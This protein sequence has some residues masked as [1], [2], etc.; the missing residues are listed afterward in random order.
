L[1]SLCAGVLGVA[2]LDPDAGFVEQG[3]DSLSLLRVVAAAG[4]RGL[5]VPP[6]LLADSRCLRDVAGWL[7][8]AS[9]ARP[10][11]L[12]ADRLRQDIAQVLHET[13]LPRPAAGPAPPAAQTILMTG[14]TGFFGGHLLVELLRQTEAEIVC[15][16]RASGARAGHE[17]LTQALTQHGL[18]VRTEE[19]RRLGVVAGDLTQ[20]LMGLAQATWDDLARRIDAI[21]H[22]AAH[23]NLALGYDRLRPDNVLGTFEVLRLWSAQ[24]PCWLHH[25]S[26]L[27]VLVATDAA[28]PAPSGQ[29][30]LGEEIDLSRTQWVHGGYA[31]S[32]WAAEWLVRQAT[33][34]AGVTHYRPGLIT[35]DSR[36][37]PLPRRDFLT[38]FL[39]GL[40]RLGCLPPCD[41][42]AL[43][44]DVTPVDYAA[45]ALAYLSLHAA[46]G[47]GDTFH[48]AGPR[49]VSLA[50]LAAALRLA[51]VRLDEVDAGGWRDR[52][53]RFVSDDPEAAAACLALCRGLPGTDDL[54]ERYRTLDLFQATGVRFGTE[55][56]QAGLA[57]LG[58][59]CVAIDNAL[60]DR[61]VAAALAT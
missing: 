43:W 8:G 1:L 52:L 54:F 44:L 56:T 37:G 45:R 3:G 20:P 25:V 29:V 19:R 11:A 10:G 48:L 61:Y 17:H 53:L 22:V 15:L 34:G 42:A 35:P 50:E 31:Q 28:D 60:L 2:A 9:D 55:R 13:P 58:I 40:A 18:S 57:G 23:V 14:A 32:K 24:R 39:R 12:R 4:A 21:Y 59:V 36:G 27:S 16:V 49:A 33:G 5:V 41:P 47:I 38:L 30:L 6:A 26:T 7:D 46:G 51:G